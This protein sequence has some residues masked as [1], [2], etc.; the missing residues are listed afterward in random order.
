MAFLDSLR[1]L[2]LVGRCGIEIAPNFG[3]KGWLIVLHGQEVVGF[4]IEDAL[5]NVWIASH[6][7]NRDQ[8]TFE[9]DAL[10]QCRDSGD[11]VGFFI[12]CLLAQHQAVSRGERGYQV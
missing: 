8:S 6:S 11:L 10:H 4:G 9:V 7:I 5:S 1:P 2:K 12:G 3:M